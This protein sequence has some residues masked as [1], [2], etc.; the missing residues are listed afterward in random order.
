[1][2]VDIINILSDYFT[3]GNLHNRHYNSE[4][5]MLVTH[6]RCEKWG[7]DRLRQTNNYVYHSVSYAG[8]FTIYQAVPEHNLA[9]Q[10][11]L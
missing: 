11:F 9:Q 8:Y 10:L 7:M 4:T 2:Q 3:I 6:H 5:G 1:M